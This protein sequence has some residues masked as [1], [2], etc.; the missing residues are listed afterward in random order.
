[1][2]LISPGSTPLTKIHTSY[3]DPHLVPGSVHVENMLTVTNALPERVIVG[4]D[5]RR[6]MDD[7]VTEAGVSYSRAGTEIAGGGGGGMGGLD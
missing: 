2:Y 1:M 5:L 3:Q 7:A 4:A 6:G